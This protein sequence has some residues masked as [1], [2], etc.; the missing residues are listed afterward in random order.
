MLIELRGDEFVKR[1]NAPMKFPGRRHPF[2]MSCSNSRAQSA[3]L[4][5]ARRVP[6]LF[7]MLLVLCFPN[8]HSAPLFAA[9][10][11]S[12]ASSPDEA[13]PAVSARM[14]RL[15]LGF[16]ST[17][18][19]GQ[20]LPVR[21]VAEGLK[22]GQSVRLQII[23]SDARGDQC[24]SIVAAGAASNDGRISLDGVFS[25]GRMD[26]VLSVQLLDEN[27]SVLMTHDVAIQ[28][29]K[30]DEQPEI[31]SA[32]GVLRQSPT[33]VLTVG[34][35]RG[36]ADLSERLQKNPETIDVLT[37]LSVKSWNDLPSDFRAYESVD[38]IFLT[39]E[40]DMSESVALA[41]R[42]W[43]LSG[44]HLI[45]SCGETTDRLLASPLGKWLQ[46]QFG[47]PATDYL[48]QT[49]D[50]TSLQ[51]YVIGATA[52]QTNRN[53]V[54]VMRMTSTQPAIVVGSLTGPLVL[55]N[56]A[57]AG[58][59]TL[60]GV[61]LNRPPLSS[62]IS[63]SQCCEL[64]LFDTLVVART[65]QVQGG[66]RISSTGVSDLSTQLAAAVDAVPQEARWSTWHAMLLMLAFLAVVG[67]LDYFVVVR[68]LQRPRLTWLTFP[69]IV[70]VACLLSVM[71]SKGSASGAV[72][73]A[74]ALV[75]LSH[76]G[77]VEHVRSRTWGSVSTP[78]TQYAT[79]SAKHADWLN[80][81][82][83]SSATTEQLS[84]SGRAEDIYGGMYRPG[85]AGL[86]RQTSRRSDVSPAE[87]TAIPLIAGGSTSVLAEQNSST[88]AHRLFQSRLTLPAS[89]LLEGTVVHQLPS[90]LRNWIVVCHNR[91]YTSSAKA[92]DEERVLEPGEEWSRHAGNVRVSDIREFLRGARLLERPNGQDGSQ[93]NSGSQ[94]QVPYDILGR[95][96][97][98]ILLMVSLY[99]AV[100]GDQY[101][102]LQNHTLRHDEVS[103]TVDLNCA[104]LIG[105]IDTPSA[106][107]VL[108]GQ[109]LTSEQSPVV[110]RFFLPVERV[111]G[112]AETFADPKADEARR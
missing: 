43:I 91:L 39:T 47:I 38:A 27:N 62:W 72:S 14:T 48:Q 16:Q 58:M 28:Q 7:A 101:V 80:K 78:E 12:S 30:S 35:P 85:G 106:D 29:K 83:D 100:G 67:P 53:P 2:L 50:L 11:V 3:G 22:A 40:F 65:G 13:T 69:V 54:T 66:S 60:V 42:K 77:D 45:V 15:A 93:N 49:L 74:A 96:P 31:C 33:T 103:D 19:V 18:R 32:L 104:M 111:F 34:S 82:S 71:A 56:A 1:L 61:D 76:D 57:G 73:R 79:L 75:D 94:G 8:I 88:N 20:N 10:P 95:D 46:P 110:V 55:R 26:G 21:M 98:D 107:L 4:V 37:W 63:L 92:T 89:G 52:L 70:G 102:R 112:E 24:E 17:G 99:E 41:I 84:W 81:G 44:G 25:I 97:F 105:V 59:V 9:G 108:N 68:L 6:A 90:A 5:G 23:A 36:I 109:P 87:F 51:N 86:G 64:L